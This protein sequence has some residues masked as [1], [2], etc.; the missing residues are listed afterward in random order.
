MCVLIC[1]KSHP[2]SSIADSD[3]YDCFASLQL[4]SETMKVNAD[5]SCSGHALLDSQQKGVYWRARAA[6]T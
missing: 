5:L 1:Q 6:R 4:I 2:K 3:P